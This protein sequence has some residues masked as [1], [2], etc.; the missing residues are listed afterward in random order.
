TGRRGLSPVFG[1][2]HH[3]EV[4]E[5]DVTLEVRGTVQGHLYDPD[6]GNQG[7]PGATLQLHSQ[8]IRWFK[9]YSSTGID[10]E[11]SFEGIPE[12]DFDVRTFRNRRRA[13]GSGRIEQ[14][15]QIYVLDLYLARQSSLSIRVLAAKTGADD[16]GET[17]LETITSRVWE[18]TGDAGI[19]GASLDN[20][21]VFDPLRPRR[22]HSLVAREINGKRRVDFSFRLQPGEDRVKDLRV[23]AI[24]TVEVTTQTSTGA[25]LPGVNVELKNAFSYSHGVG[26]DSVHGLGRSESHYGTSDA[27]GRVVFPNIW[28]GR[29][30]VHITDPVSGLRGRGSGKLYWDGQ[31]KTLTVKLQP[32]GTVNGTVFLSDGVTPAEG[33]LVALDAAERSWQ[34]Q[35]AGADGSFAFTDIPLGSY[36]LIAQQADGPGTYELSDHIGVD[37]EVDGHTLVLDDADPFVVDVVPPFGSQHIDRNSDVVVTFSEPIRPCGASCGAWVYL[38]EISSSTRP[39]IQ[40][41]WSANGQTLTL[42]PQSP[43][44]NSTG[45]KLV[46]T[47]NLKDLARRSLAWRVVSS[48]YTADTVAPRI[49]D[50]RPR[51]D[52]VQV[53]VTSAIE[54]TFNES[55]DLTSLS[56]AFEVVDLTAGQSLT[57]TTQTSLDDRRVV[58][59]PVV[60]FAPDRR[61]EV[62]VTGVAD[63]AGNAMGLFTSQFW[64]PDETPPD[65][66]WGAPSPGQV[67]TAGDAIDVLADITDNRGVQSVTLSLGDWSRSFS[68]GPYSWRIPAPVVTQAGPVEIFAEA[69]DIFGNVASGTLEVWVEPL[70]NSS[71]P[72]IAIGCPT[73]GDLVAPGVAQPVSFSALDD[74]ALESAWLIVD[75]ER[76][77]E[78]TPIWEAS[79]DLLFEW[80]PEAGAAPGQVFLA[81]LEARDFAGNVGSVPLDFVAPSGE[82]LAG[83]QSLIPR[84]GALALAAGEFTVDSPLGLGD[85]TLLSGANLRAPEGAALAVD[86]LRVQCGGEARLARTDV[87]GDV[88]VEKGGVLGPEQLGHLDVVAQGITVEAG[89]LV[90]GRH[91]GYNGE[92]G[93]QPPS[94][95]G[96]WG[97]PGRAKVDGGS[98]GGRG[99]WY[100]SE[101]DGYDSVYVPTMA[102]GGGSR[103]P[104]TF[105]QNGGD[106]GGIVWLEASAELRIDGRVDVRGGDGLGAVKSSAGAGGSVRL[107][108]QRLFGSGSVDAG[109]GARGRDGGGGGRVVLS[110]PQM[111]LDTSTQVNVAGGIG[112]QPEPGLAQR[113][114]GSGSL[115]V[116]TAGSVYGT[117]ILDGGDIPATPEIE[118]HRAAVLTTLGEIAVTATQVQGTDLLLYTG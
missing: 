78:L 63:G 101:P 46:V 67:F 102:G 22:L 29:Y 74:Q 91:R 47:R 99:T 18:S 9:T 105:G 90:D 86:G 72:A 64:T 100:G 32:S 41:L 70:S 89:G 111:E 2:G 92:N 79:E 40:H 37:G 103:D 4:F 10:G 60:D 65:V 11:Y 75:G 104:S 81:A 52:A 24:G 110:A 73:A 77:A 62:R 108:A 48:F 3:E 66:G 14:E 26:A 83:D 33:A 55:V 50:F 118:Q 94:N 113:I 98:H 42:R 43:L 85:V 28:E 35:Y 20:P 15:D 36:D 19:V 116:E 58:L 68:S 109:G 71:P 106:G 87:L 59:T 96:P 7:V 39:P 16:P 30:D 69:V 56:G 112:L 31:I 21:A 38:Q 49:I 6:A 13:Q 45:Y 114:A 34:V 95:T 25:V 57:V 84:S 93:A 44:K 76:V 80:T 117:L 107:A 1:L 17:V 61:I 115:L 54:I 53:P 88:T 82:T 23:K 97:P 8:G 5:Q 51:A 12:G 27:A